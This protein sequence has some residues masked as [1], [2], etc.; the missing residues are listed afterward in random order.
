MAVARLDHPVDF[1]RADPLN[2]G[3]HPADLIDGTPGVRAGAR[4]VA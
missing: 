2:P 3:P 1:Q 4:Q